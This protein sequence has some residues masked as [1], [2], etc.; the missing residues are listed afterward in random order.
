MTVTDEFMELDEPKAHPNH[1]VPRDGYDRPMVVPPLGGRPKPMARASKFGDVVDDKSN[2]A[3]WQVRMALAGA[4]R[5]PDLLAEKFGKLSDEDLDDKDVKRAIN[6]FAE[7]C[8]EMAGAS[9]KS[10][11][12]T[13]LHNLTEYVDQNIPIP[14]GLASEADAELISSYMFETLKFDSV[15]SIEQFC[16]NEIVGVAGTFDRVVEYQGDLYITDLKTGGSLEYGGNTIAAQ[17]S[18]YSRAELYD[19]ARFPAPSR[20]DKVAW[21]RWKKTEFTAEDAAKAYSP[22]APGR[23][24]R[25]DV[26]LVIHLPQSGGECRIVPVNLEMGWDIVRLSEKILEARKQSKKVWGD[27]I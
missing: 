23:G 4:A 25:Q 9:R 19:F 6:Q 22:I 10:A 17:L 14:D 13:H 20:F 27:P 26:G 15:Y 8:Q 2:I 11:R 24:V 12:G 18:I 7:Q 1:T 21:D 16:V 5:R 3:K